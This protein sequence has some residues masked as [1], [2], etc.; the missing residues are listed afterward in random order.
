MKTEHL[1]K[2]FGIFAIDDPERPCPFAAAWEDIRITPSIRGGLETLISSVSLG[3]GRLTFAAVRRKSRASARQKAGMRCLDL[4]LGGTVQRKIDGK[5]YPAAVAVDCSGVKTLEAQS[6]DARVLHFQLPEEEIEAAL[7]FSARGR[8]VPICPSSGRAI[9]DLAVMGCRNLERLPPGL[10]GR[11]A[12]SLGKALTVRWAGV[13]LEGLPSALRPEPRLGRRKL[14][15]LAE[16]AHADHEHP[17]DV[18]ALATYCG[19]GVR[20][21]QKS[22][23]RHLETSPAAFLRS[24]RLDKA[25]KLLS[26]GSF[27]VIEAAVHTGFLNL[28]RFS[29][30]YRRKFGELPSATLAR[31]PRP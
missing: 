5:V 19:N 27:T 7:G 8:R 13:V 31:A 6:G 2:S 24:L 3:P 10:Q 28:H 22:F 15:E 23:R 4:V 1:L 21:L 26:T 18:I 9:R 14:S 17:P 20:A 30:A 25:R 12:R 11:F 16:W 29:A